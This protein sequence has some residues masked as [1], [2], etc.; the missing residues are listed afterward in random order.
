[1]HGGCA[2]HLRTCGRPPLGAQAVSALQP[3]HGRF[4]RE[5]QP[6]IGKLRN[7]LLRR[8][9]GIARTVSTVTTCASST[10][11]SALLGRCCGPQRRSPISGSARQ[12]PTV[13]AEIPSRSHAG[14]RRAPAACASAT[15]STITS[16]SAR[17]CRRPRPPHTECPLFF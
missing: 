14:A 6:F 1:M 12:R 16:R 17:S 9:A 10:G 13:R 2:S 11:A 7:Q 8:Q 5:V 4:G 3:V 15:R